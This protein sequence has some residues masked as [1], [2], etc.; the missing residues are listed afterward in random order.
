ML[1]T[2]DHPKWDVHEV[3]LT[4][5]SY[6]GMSMT[7]LMTMVAEIQSTNM[8]LKKGV[9]KHKFKDLFKKNFVHFAILDN[10][11]EKT[12]PSILGFASILRCDYNMNFDCHMDLAVC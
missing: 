3:T 1:F 4:K 12:H 11:K 2:N 10:D 5:E 6:E 8:V 7:K 9:N